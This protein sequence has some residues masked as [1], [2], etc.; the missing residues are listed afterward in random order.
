MHNVSCVAALA[1]E[2]CCAFRHCAAACRLRSWRSGGRRAPCAQ[3]YELTRAQ[4]SRG[5]ED[6]LLELQ[7]K[8]EATPHHDRRAHVAGALHRQMEPLVQAMR[9]ALEGLGDARAA[10]RQA[11]AYYLEASG[12][13]QAAKDR[14]AEGARLAKARAKVPGE[15]AARV[16]GAPG[17]GSVSPGSPEHRAGMGTWAE[18]L[19]GALRSGPVV[20]PSTIQDEEAHNG[21]FW[22]GETAVPG[23][24]VAFYPGVV[25]RPK[26]H[27][28]IPG[29]PLISHGNPYLILR[30][31]H[32][33]VDGK[34]WGFGEG[35][36]I[37]YR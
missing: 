36:P 9:A 16:P 35:R 33:I 3:Y 32:S 5:T 34:V 1:A 22:R 23:Q 13:T 28:F 12:M 4:G 30:P 7:E 11:E 17:P 14:V 24:I 8:A 15:G 21:L 31:D 2:S 10:E 18:A 27:S 29:Y 6:Q 25:Y 20:R 26:W 19:F 37:P